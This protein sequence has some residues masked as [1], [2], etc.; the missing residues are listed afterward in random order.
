MYVE[1]RFIRVLDE[2]DDTGA[3]VME[4]AC[5]TAA[6]A[7]EEERTGGGRRLGECLW[8]VGVPVGNT[9]D[10]MPRGL[11]RCPLLLVVAAPVGFWRMGTVARTTTPTPRNT[12][13]WHSC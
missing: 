4:G 1:Q 6:A 3:V 10:I 13:G 2:L 7:A 9:T 11:A 5:W 12:R 8:S